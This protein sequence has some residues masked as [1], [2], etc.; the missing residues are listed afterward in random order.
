LKKEKNS[1]MDSIHND[2]V[3]VIILNEN[4]DK[5]EELFRLKKG[6]NN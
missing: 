4:E 2:Q 3:R 1:K 6:L 5:S